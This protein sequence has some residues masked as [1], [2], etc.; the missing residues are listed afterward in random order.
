M[1]DELDLELAGRIDELHRTI[2]AHDAAV[3]DVRSA[4]DQSSAALA[5]R[6]R[7][8]VIDAW[9]PVVNTMTS[10]GYSAQMELTESP[11]ALLRLRVAMAAPTSTL[12]VSHDRLAQQIVL[13]DDLRLPGS[14]SERT[15]RSVEVLDFNAGWLAARTRETALRL[16]EEWSAAR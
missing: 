4:A 1:S 5:Q 2:R 3:A 16:V 9:E 12:L 15:T 11:G 14:N 10:R 7:G 6:I 13:T 8:A